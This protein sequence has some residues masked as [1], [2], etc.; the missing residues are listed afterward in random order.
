ML[1]IFA[2]EFF[3]KKFASFVFLYDLLKKKKKL[4][5]E[6][7]S[8]FNFT[9]IASTIKLLQPQIIFIVINLYI[10]TFNTINILRKMNYYSSY[11]SKSKKNLSTSSIKPF[12]ILIRKNNY[13]QILI[14]R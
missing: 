6:Y 7:H 10:N 12:T 8:I 11:Q 14:P 5:F 4:R 1:H 9:K 13:P 2:K 3:N